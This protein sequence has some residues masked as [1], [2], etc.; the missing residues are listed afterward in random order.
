MSLTGKTQDCRS[1]LGSSYSAG[2]LD[3]TVTVVFIIIGKGE[4]I[5]GIISIQTGLFLH[6]IFWRPPRVLAPK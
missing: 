4:N 2:E 5:S 3:G 1:L 6:R